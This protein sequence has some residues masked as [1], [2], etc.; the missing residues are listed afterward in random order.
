LYSKHQ[1]ALSKFQ[2]NFNNKI[3]N[4]CFSI[5]I[6][7]MSN[8]IPGFP[9]LVSVV[10]TGLKPIRN[11]AYLLIS[12]SSLFDFIR[13]KN[14]SPWFS[15]KLVSNYPKVTHDSSQACAKEDRI[16]LAQCLDLHTNRPG[17]IAV[18][19]DNVYAERMRAVGMTFHPRCDRR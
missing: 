12:M 5:Q 3:Q 19:S 9:K 7:S 13:Q 11:S 16:P 1:I 4:I 2:I 18:I 10:R 6:I 15:G 17:A 14:E 8:A